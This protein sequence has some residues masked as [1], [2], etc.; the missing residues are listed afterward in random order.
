MGAVVDTNV[1]SVAQGLAAQAD[2]QCISDCQDRLASI[3]ENGIVFL[4]GLD[5]IFESYISQV[6]YRP[7][8]G[9]GRAFVSW[10]RDARFANS[11]VR[12][13]TVTPRNGDWRRFEEFP[14]RP[15]LL[16]FDDDDHVFVAVALASGEAPPPAILNAVD[17]DWAEHHAALTAAGVLVEFI[18]PQHCQP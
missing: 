18:C 12:Q 5:L 16:Q 17:S 9:M 13:V 11:R 10:L 8:P 3:V 14:D 6:G 7:R 2:Q 15:D 4:D 1:V